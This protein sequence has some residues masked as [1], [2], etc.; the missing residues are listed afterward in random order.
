MGKGAWT[1]LFMVA[2]VSVSQ[3]AQ[4]HFLGRDPVPPKTGD[5]F[6]FNRY[7]YAKNNPVINIDPDGRYACGSTDKNDCAQINGFV[8]TMHTAMSHLDPNSAA[9]ARL[10]AVSKHIGTLGDGNGV[11]LTPGSLREGMIAQADSATL[12]TIDV[13]QA[14]TLSAPFRAFNRGRSASSL[15]SVFGAGA[16]AHE[17]QHQ[18]DYVNPLM[19]YPT[20]R[21]SEYATEINAYTTE[22][23]VAKGM[24]AST[25]LF[26]PGALPKDINARVQQA[27]MAS[28]NAFCEVNG[29]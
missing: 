28:T 27:A 11:T 16:V 18:L 6:G 5:V 2:T 17:G 29:C 25:D 12:M 4:A 9:Y 21:R 14:T 22:L 19:G 10:S 1:G 7:A 20:D 23:G 8:N 15:A 24:G 26:A 3:V 13:K